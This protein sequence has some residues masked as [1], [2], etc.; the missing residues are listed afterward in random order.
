MQF[1]MSLGLDGFGPPH[2]PAGRFRDVIHSNAIANLDPGGFT[3]IMWVWLKL[4]TGEI[5]QRILPF[6]FFTTTR[7]FPSGVTVYSMGFVR[8]STMRTFCSGVEC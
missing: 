8:S 2:E 5:W 4:A 7:V 3:V 1:W 6:L